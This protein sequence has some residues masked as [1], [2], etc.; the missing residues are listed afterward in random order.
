MGEQSDKVDQKA[1]GTGIVVGVK[2][3]RLKAPSWKF[4]LVVVAT[5]V[6]AMTAG[7]GVRWLNDRNTR[8]KPKALPAA[9][10]SSQEA[11]IKGDY[12][13][14]HQ[15][16]SDALKNAKTPQQKYEL[17]F[18]QGTTYT[19]QAKYK[20]AIASY[21]EATAFRQTQSLYYNMALAAEQLDDKS[22]A[23]S[24]YK[25]AIQLIP[26]TNPVGDGDKTSYEARIS[27]LEGQP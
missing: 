16:L 9:I 26:K 10:Q 22:A 8:P 19:N 1:T 11:G 4:M 12:D 17:Y 5:I 25:K 7:V 2:E 14:A 18:Q 20:E 23:I 13:T 3:R 15:E 27:E 21:K 6:I 24:Y